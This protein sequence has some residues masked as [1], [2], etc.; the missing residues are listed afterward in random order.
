MPRKL[1]NTRLGFAAPAIA[2]VLAALALPMI[3]QSET[4]VLGMKAL[5]E[6]Q[7]GGC[8]GQLCV[9]VYDEPMAT[10]CEYRAEYACYQKSKCEKQADGKCGWT[11]TP[12]LQA[13]LK[14]PPS[15]GAPEVK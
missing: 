14:N 11:E 1:R 9:S 7:P 2:L 3:A 10:T 15:L 12:E 6:C 5:G 8:S 13:C 4:P